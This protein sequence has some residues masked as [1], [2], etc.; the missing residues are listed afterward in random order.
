MAAFVRLLSLTRSCQ[1]ENIS[2]DFVLVESKRKT[3]IYRRTFGSRLNVRPQEGPH[4]AHVD[5]HWRWR[6]AW[7]LQVVPVA[8]W[9]ARDRSRSR[10][11]WSNPRL[12]WDGVALPSRVGC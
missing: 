3:V 5:D 11:L 1:L 6:C 2:I 10:R 9:P 7:Q 4:E 8:T 12:G